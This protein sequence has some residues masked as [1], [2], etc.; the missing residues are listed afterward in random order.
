M[1]YDTRREPGVRANV[2]DIIYEHSNRNNNNAVRVRR[3]YRRVTS[4]W[5][6]FQTRRINYVP[7]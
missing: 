3:N 2:C 1:R 4:E 5:K 6:H 7:F